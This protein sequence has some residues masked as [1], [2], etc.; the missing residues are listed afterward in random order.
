MKLSEINAKILYE[1]DSN[2]QKR[3]GSFEKYFEFLQL[4]LKRESAWTY[5]KNLS[6]SIREGVKDWVT[7]KAKDKANAEARYEAAMQ[8]ASAMNK[9]YD[10]ALAELQTKYNT[11]GDDTSK[12]SDELTAYTDLKS[13]KFDTDLEVK[14]ARTHFNDANEFY[15]RVSYMV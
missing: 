5:G 10:A 8:A 6:D 11:F 15:G 9:N 12:Y 2:L 7:G 14:L 13:A 1:K 4:Q 3:F